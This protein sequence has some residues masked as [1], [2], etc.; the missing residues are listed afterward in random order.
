MRIFRLLAL[1]LLFSTFTVHSKAQSSAPAPPTVS[2]SPYQFHLYGQL[3]QLFGNPAA[4]PPANF[5]TLPQRLH[6]P[7]ILPRNT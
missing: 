4:K 3:P 7:F 5:L 1:S 2:G 6:N